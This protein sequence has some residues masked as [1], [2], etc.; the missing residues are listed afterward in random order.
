MLAE[1]N[2]C[3][4]FQV[5]F[6]NSQNN[7]LHSGS[8]WWQT[9]CGHFTES[10]QSIHPS[11][12]PWGCA[13]TCPA[14]VHFSPWTH[15]GMTRVGGL[16]SWLRARGGHGQSTTAPQQSTEEKSRDIQKVLVRGTS[17]FQARGEQS[18][19]LRSLTIPRTGMRHGHQ[20]VAVV[21][22]QVPETHTC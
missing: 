7:L 4:V 10:S 19:C 17:S 22:R 3:V 5:F 13:P 6:N 18:C 16:E 8:G 21:G 15:R 1:T 11:V 20:Q 2:D 9:S 12:H 14:S